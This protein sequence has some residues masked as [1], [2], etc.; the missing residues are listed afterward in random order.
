MSATAYLVVYEQQA[1]RDELLARVPSE[2][3]AAGAHA[4]PQLA[5]RV[6]LE[7]LRAQ[8]R[9]GAQAVQVRG[10]N[11]LDGGAHERRRRHE[12]QDVRE[13]GVL[14][15][16]RRKRDEPRDDGVEVRD[17]AAVGA[18]R[19]V[20]GHA[21][22]VR[23]GDAARADGGL[24]Q[25]DVG[26]GLDSQTRH[27]SSWPCWRRTYMMRRGRRRRTELPRRCDLG[28]LYTQGILRSTQAWHEGRSSSHFLR[29]LRLSFI[30]SQR[31]RTSRPPAGRQP[32]RETRREN[33][34]GLAAPSRASRGRH[35]Y[36]QVVA[37]LSREPLGGGMTVR[38]RAAAD[39][40]LM[41]S[42][43]ETMMKEM[44]RW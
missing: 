22:R 11:G 25:R 24:S 27:V 15:A 7:R 9:L 39:G 37:H 38:R 21:A 28:V 43:A 17:E 32:A 8:L 10:G 16:A 44:T 31:Q 35:V 29:R 42:L 5:Q 41:A 12:R 20:R 30:K 26:R 19:Q 4:V 2:L 34:P 36:R 18:E 14:R 3:P 33:A 6:E 23:V 40:R 1:R 13:E